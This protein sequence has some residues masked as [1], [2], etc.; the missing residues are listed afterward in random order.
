MDTYIK[1][2][3]SHEQIALGHGTANKKKAVRKHK[4]KMKKQI[5]ETGKNLPK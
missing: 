2:P 5:N 3:E 4:E 1:Q